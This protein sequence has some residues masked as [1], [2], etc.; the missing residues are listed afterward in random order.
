[1]VDPLLKNIFPANRGSVYNVLGY[2]CLRYGDVY[3]NHYSDSWCL[4]L[5]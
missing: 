3:G 4:S 1:M 2:H 5:P